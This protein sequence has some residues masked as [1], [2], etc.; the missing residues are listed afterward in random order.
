MD[1]LIIKDISVS[2]E[3]RETACLKADGA[4]WIADD[5][6]LDEAKRTISKMLEAW[7]SRQ[8]DA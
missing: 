8:K 2:D 3:F 5:L 4:I 1:D 6:T 7:R